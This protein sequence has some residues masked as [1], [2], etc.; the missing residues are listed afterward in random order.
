MIR[1]GRPGLEVA[2]AVTA[3]RDELV[4][5]LWNRYAGE[6]GGSMPMRG[7]LLAVGGY[8]KRRLCPYS[9][10]DLLLIVADRDPTPAAKFCEPFFRD[11]YDVGLDVGFSVREAD[12]TWGSAIEDPRFC[13]S[14][15][16]VRPLWGDENLLQDWRGRFLRFL[17][18]NSARLI[19]AVDAARSR[20]RAEYGDTVYLLQPNV[21]RSPG[22]LRDV[23][24][25]E[26][27]AALRFQETA[28]EGLT[29][30][31]AVTEEEAA[32]IREAEDFLLRVRQRL[33][34]EAGKADDILSRAAQWSLAEAWGFSS[35]GGLLGVERFM[36]EYFRLT[37]QVDA[38]RARVFAHVDPRRRLRRTWGKV[39]GR[40]VG[41]HARLAGGE[42]VL[43]REAGKAAPRS[44]LPLLS[45]LESALRYDAEISPDAWHW[46]ALHRDALPGE[47]S[48]SERERFFNLLGRT[49]RLPSLLRHLHA[50]RLLERFIPGF[51]PARGL[52]QFN[53]YH[54]FT[55]DQHSLI[56]LE[57]AVELSRDQGLLGR[58]YAA[59]HDKAILHA[60]ILLHD[61]G[62]GYDEDHC[63]V[64]AK[65]AEETAR[66]FRLP[67]D[68]TRHLVFLVRNHLRMNHLALRRDLSDEK[69]V[70][71]LA[72]EVGS[73]ELLRML[74][75]LTAVDLM[76]VGPDNWTGWKADLLAELYQRAMR[77]ISDSGDIIALGD[78]LLEER[79]REILAQPAARELDSGFRRLVAALPEGY[80]LSADPRRIA[81][82][83]KLLAALGDQPV[84]ISAEFVPAAGSMIWTVAT[85]EKIAEGVFHR[86]TG[87]FTSRG[88]SILSAQIHT[89]AGG[90]ILDRF[91]VR[92]PFYREE[93][94]P[95]RLREIREELL[96]SLSSSS[97]LEP[98][99]RERWTPTDE[100]LDDLPRAAVRVEIDN[101]SLPD[102]TI[103]EVFADDRAGLLYRI[104]RTLFEEG[105]SVWR[106]KV[107]TYL[108]QVVDVFY[109]TDREGA[110]LSDAT[111]L[112]RIKNRLLDA[113]HRKEE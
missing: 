47:P 43:T 54:K 84:E 78:K 16:H 99:F 33:H 86:L 81:Q 69:L 28:L 9:D 51:G 1:D 103:I 60:A 65:I 38:V 35:G 6:T 29:R 11:L 57:R 22:G 56:A 97:R 64:G 88:L 90:L 92:D 41:P 102:F 18:R 70:V 19:L 13:T 48:E 12:R 58:T 2:E 72:V 30:F 53:Q 111:L 4:L 10:V 71:D 104:A 32:A 105:C 106:A 15:L 98:V 87:A 80:L 68:R 45:L 17:R 27:L 79:R 101:A 39:V 3:M 91:W 109:V 31:H 61:L 8:A 83:L 113:I 24:F 93:P 52:L 42:I 44:Y 25:I 74:Y 5:T 20:E 76:A 36:R 26:W 89:L 40:K 55:V 34:L 62:K 49:A 112:A 94:P 100:R 67:E 37:E 95:D 14:L 108:D 96:R 82:D 66:R 50:L 77:C 73:P 7:C 75:V 107:G 63:T 23:Q 21:K 59:V 110:R 85:R 46:L